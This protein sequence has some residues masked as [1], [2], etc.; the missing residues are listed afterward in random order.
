M[1]PRKIEPTGNRLILLT[2]DELRIIQEKC[3]HAL[4][5]IIWRDNTIYSADVNLIQA[6]KQAED[7]LDSG[8]RGAL[9]VKPV[10]IAHMDWMNYARLLTL[11]YNRDHDYK[12]YTIL[13]KDA[14]MPCINQKQLLYFS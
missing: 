8:L 7:G 9:Q 5:R 14:N 1:W 3:D 12:Y 10:S 2:D 11:W 13:R 4:S 6:I